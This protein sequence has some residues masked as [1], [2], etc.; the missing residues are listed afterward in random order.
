MK[1]VLLSAFVAS[2]V[3]LSG[4][5][6]LGP[7]LS[8]SSLSTRLK[9]E[10]DG[11]Q[12]GALADTRSYADKGLEQNYIIKPGDSVLSYGNARFNSYLNVK[13]YYPWQA[14]LWRI[15]DGL[16]KITGFCYNASVNS[17]SDHMYW[18]LEQTAKDN[19]GKKVEKLAYI[20][21]SEGPEDFVAMHFS[22]DLFYAKNAGYHDFKSVKDRQKRVSEG[23]YN[24][25][26][27]IDAI[28]L[29]HLGDERAEPTMITQ[30]FNP[31]VDI[32]KEVIPSVEDN[33]RTLTYKGEEGDKLILGYTETK[34]LTTGQEEKI[35]VDKNASGNYVVKGVSFTLTNDSGDTML[36]LHSYF[37]G[38]TKDRFMD[39]LPYQPNFEMFTD[40]VYKL[41]DT[42]DKM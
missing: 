22:H 20:P 18:W 33:Y 32:V 9:A 14:D 6:A 17:R 36:R 1:K 31:Y 5:S 38:D 27:T 35:S 23:R 7:D 39:M 8:L 42:K 13:A 11:S 2:S 3:V 19:P 34:G 29:D 21:F 12:W 37:D 4:C 24:L 30:M 41:I 26:T 10:V 28:P 40:D 16:H 15:P 25:S